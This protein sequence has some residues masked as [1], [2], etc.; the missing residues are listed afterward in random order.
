MHIAIVID[1][2]YDKGNGTS[3]TAR[4]T[5]RELLKK[6][7]EVTVLCTAIEG[8]ER[9]SAARMWSSLT[10]YRCPYFKRR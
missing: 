3:I 9:A 4:N 1:C 8:G 7:I 2:Y 6:G 5:V 10:S